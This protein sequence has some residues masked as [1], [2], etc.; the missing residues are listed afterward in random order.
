MHEFIPIL[1]RDGYT[2]A[3]DL[4][5][6]AH[7]SI[8]EDPDAFSCSRASVDLGDRRRNDAPHGRPTAAGFGERSTSTGV[9]AHLQGDR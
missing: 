7:H 3:A 5:A 4:L 9:S 1:R 2:A 8:S 6:R